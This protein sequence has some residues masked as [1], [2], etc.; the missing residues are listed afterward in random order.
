[1]VARND[2]P[3]AERPY[4]DLVGMLENTVKEFPDKIAVDFLDRT[5]DYQTIW[6]EAR[7]LA[8]A[9][10]AQRL[11]KGDRVALCLPNSPYSIVA[12]YGVL[13]AGGV[14]VNCNP[15]YSAP[16]L[17][18]Q[19]SDAGA[20]IIITVDLAQITEKLLPQLHNEKLTTFIVCPF[21]AALPPVKRILFSLLKSREIARLPDDERILNYTDLIERR[22]Q[23]L[24][25]EIDPEDLAVLQYTGGTT[26]RPKGAMLSHRNLVT[27]R[28]QCEMILPNVRQGEEIFLCVLPFFH[29]FAMTVLMNLGISLGAKLVLL[30]RFELKQTLKAIKTHQPT[31]FPAVPTLYTALV[32]APEL[33]TLD[34]SALRY[35]I[36]GGAPLPPALRQEF[37]EK[38]G[39]RLVEGYGLSE[40]GPVLTVNSF[41]GDY[42]DGSIGRPLPQTE[43]VI[44]DLE[45][46]K[47]TVAAGKRGEICAKGPQ[48]MAGY[49][50]RPEETEETL[51]DGYLRTGDVGMMDE[52]GFIFIVDRL[53]DMILC[54]GFNVYP[55][56]IEDALYEHPGVMEVTVIG[57]KDDYRGEAPKAF[58]KRA[59]GH[60]TLDA[61]ALRAFLES[62]LS[63]IEMP[64]AFEFRNELPKTMIGKLS[65]K[66]LVAEEAS[67]G[68]T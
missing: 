52:E 38:T 67:K 40:S 12:Y 31:C 23:P 53:K 25:V 51:Q 45:D 36:S 15:L 7:C 49:Y 19:I 41:T 35:C 16:E 9:L 24:P 28:I 10:Q 65:K 27:N 43:I 54:S 60:E 30:P 14:V 4:R 3:L 42:R 5:F 50:K 26:G 22:G 6:N 47:K 44:R 29:V 48:V 1:M 56:N 68:K 32:R 33:A 46:S 39:V 62:R 55:R 37:I 59:P 64:R 20:K 61:E 66:E 58:I 8:A 18:S 57:V 11:A 34:L 17:D 63:K 21:A 2:T 13:M